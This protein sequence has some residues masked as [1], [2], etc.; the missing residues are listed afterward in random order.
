[1]NSRFYWLILILILGS[2]AMGACTA[3]TPAPPATF[4]PRPT[5][6]GPG[7]FPLGTYKPDK[8]LD[9]QYMQF[10]AQG[11]FITVFADADTGTYTVNGDQITINMDSGICFNHPGTYHWEIHGDTLT[12]KPI[13]DTCT[14]SSRADEMESRLWIRQP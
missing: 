8:V 9:V 12:F 3:A 11:T 2:I 7:G 5:A 1:M 6:I 4:T 13:N 14:E 10:T